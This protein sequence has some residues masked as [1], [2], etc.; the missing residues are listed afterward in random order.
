MTDQPEYTLIIPRAVRAGPCNLAVDLGRAAVAR[1]FRVRLLY[2][3]GAI[4]RD[5]L[6]DFDEVRPWRWSDVLRLSGTVHTHGLRPDLIGWLLTWKRGCEVLTTVHIHFLADLSMLHERWKIWPAWLVWSRALARFRHRVCVSE[7]MRRYYR[8]ELPKLRFEVILNV[9]GPRDVGID[10]KAEAAASWIAQRRS[11]GLCLAYVGALTPRKN[12]LRLLDA[13]ADEPAVSIVL[14]GDGPLRDRVLHRV[15]EPAL[16]DRVRYVGSLR[17]PDRVVAECDALVL[18]SRAEG[19]PLVVLEAARV[20]RP[21]L[22]SNIAVHRELVRAGLGATFDRHNFRDLVPKARQLV[23]KHGRG[24]RS[25]PLL[26][27]IWEQRFSPSTGF[28]RYARL[29]G[30]WGQQAC[31]DV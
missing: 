28:E 11:Q 2:L 29:F 24:G 26:A 21:S 13:V 5:D 6:A 16:A 31:G 17:H 7:T 20:G 10:P 12:V 25:D 8:K 4:A 23:E 19:L 30:K 14:C 9:A 15:D 1:G 18:P 3:S 22:L 27:A